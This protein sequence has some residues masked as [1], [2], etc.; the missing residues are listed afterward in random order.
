MADIEG[1]WTDASKDLVFDLTRCGER[2][3]GRKVEADGQCGRVALTLDGNR[4]LSVEGGRGASPQEVLPIG[5]GYD[6]NVDTANSPHMIHV[7]GNIKRNLEN[8]ALGMSL[9]GFDSSVSRR[10]PALRLYLVKIGEAHCQPKP[11]S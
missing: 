8:G 2:F 4:A 10:G 5:G 3:C 6:W 11:T 9:Y 1:R 7:S